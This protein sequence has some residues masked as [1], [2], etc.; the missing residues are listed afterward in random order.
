MEGVMK[1]KIGRHTYSITREDVFLNNGKCVQLM[2][3]KVPSPH[4]FS[5]EKTPIL[6]KAAVKQLKKHPDVKEFD[7]SAQYHE[8]C[9]I[10][11]IKNG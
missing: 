5:G 11:R 10:L 8:G 4:Y 3:Q 2:T 6:S 7:A 1:L 9:T